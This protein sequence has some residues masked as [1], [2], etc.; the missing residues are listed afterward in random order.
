M[1]AVYTGKSEVEVWTA[2]FKALID[3]WD[4]VRKVVKDGTAG[5]GMWE[6]LH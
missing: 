1:W 6:Y 2:V 3:F 4:L 5:R